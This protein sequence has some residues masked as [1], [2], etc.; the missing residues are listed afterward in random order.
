ML[1]NGLS[2]Q[3]FRCGD[4]AETGEDKGAIRSVFSQQ[5]ATTI[6]A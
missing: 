5:S 2:P 6:L 3:D 1:E 4:F